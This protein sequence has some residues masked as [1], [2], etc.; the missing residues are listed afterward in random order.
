MAVM[1]DRPSPLSS[2]ENGVN[3]AADRGAAAQFGK[4]VASVGVSI[5]DDDHLLEVLHRLTLAACEFIDA[6]DYASVSLDVRDRTFT[7]CST[8][9]CTDSVDSEQYIFDDGP[10][11]TAA[12]ENTVVVADCVEG[13]PRWPRFGPAARAAGLSAVLAAPIGVAGNSMGAINLYSRARGGFDDIDEQLLNALTSATANAVSDFSVR[14]SAQETIEG[15]R[16]AMVHRAPIEQ[17]KGILMALYRIDADAAFARLVTQS[18]HE[19]VKLRDVAVGF[20]ESVSAADTT[21][22][23]HR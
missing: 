7:A 8:D 1:T 11:L 13:D 21:T 23:R 20:V 10:C 15:L 16:A 9:P 19:N 12:R 17:A 6:A 22:V 2:P 3:I 5:D 4:V 14:R 18:Q